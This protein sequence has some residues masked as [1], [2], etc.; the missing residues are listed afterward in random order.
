MHT[1]AKTFKQIKQ[2]TE[3]YKRKGGKNNRKLQTRRMI[4]FAEFIE[5]KY[6]TGCLERIGRNHVVDFYINSGLKEK[7]LNDYYYS[8]KKL[9]EL[10]G[11]PQ[12]PKPKISQIDKL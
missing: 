4:L 1:S 10:A 8:I 7:T 3:A 12:P 2:L 6:K 9:F 11:K 5:G